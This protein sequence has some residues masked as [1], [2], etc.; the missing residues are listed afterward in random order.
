M[1]ISTCILSNMHLLGN[2]INLL[3][4][5]ILLSLIIMNIQ[6]TQ[7]WWKLRLDVLESSKTGPHFT[8]KVSFSPIENILTSSPQSK[9]PFSQPLHKWSFWVTILAAMG[10]VGSYRDEYLSNK[11]WNYLS[12]N[13]AM[14]STRYSTCTL[15][16]LAT[17]TLLGILVIFLNFGDFVEYWWFS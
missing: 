4:Y 2:G 11:L 9:I 14:T 6:H 8:W 1:E 13:Q 7:F 16:F 3:I 15:N 5:I 10:L 17:R 12:A